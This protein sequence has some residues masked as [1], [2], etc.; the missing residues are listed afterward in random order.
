MMKKTVLAAILLSCIPALALAQD[1]RPGVA[2]HRGA[3][4]YLPEHTL[5]A[6]AMAYAMGVDYIEQDLVLTKDD[7]LVVLHDHSLETTTD[8]AK[9]FPGR[10]RADGS[11]YAIDFTLAE[12]KSLIVTERFDAKTGE[13][14]FKGRFPVS[15][16][17]DYRVPTFEEEL[18]QVQ[19]LNKATGN[20]IGIY[21]EVKE[22]AFHDR[23]GKP[24]MKA[25][26]DMLTKY[27]YNKKDSNCILQIFDYPAVKQSRELG[28]VGPLA[29]LVDGD[30]QL[31]TDDKDVHKFLLTPEGI[32]EVSQVADIY[33]PWFGHLAE[34][35]ADG[36]GYT[37]PEERIKAVRDTGMKLHSWT[38]RADALP[39]GFKSEDEVM[40]FL[41][42]TIK[43]D[44][45]FSDHAD[46]LIVYLKKN[47]LRD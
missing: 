5:E 23:E 31:L 18:Q 9:K 25:V 19:G 1:Y 12:I 38:Y 41:F 22:P 2:A 33:A 37:I 3:S 4:A 27:G 45:M 40:D 15:F 8:V 46:H 11:Y 6:K 28:W 24:I 36:S 44:G 42:K 43:V 14:V 30:G 26:I 20:D 35:K 34:A 21:V 47:G 17:I 10:N 13:A 16:D 39:K 32:K 7:V 29:M